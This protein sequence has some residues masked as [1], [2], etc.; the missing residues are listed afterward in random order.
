MAEEK[1]WIVNFL[2][3]FFLSKA[4]NQ[5]F[6]QLAYTFWR[7]E[8]SFADF[9]FLDRGDKKKEENGG[10]GSSVV[11]FLKNISGQYAHMEAY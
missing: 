3:L 11:R 1:H 4:K 5:V 9:L 2:S 10:E 6:A 7:H 8:A